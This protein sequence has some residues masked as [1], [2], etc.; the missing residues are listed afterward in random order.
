MQRIKLWA[1]LSSHPRNAK[2]WTIYE[3][4]LARLLVLAYGS[5]RRR[6]RAYATKQ[7]KVLS[8]KWKVSFAGWPSCNSLSRPLLPRYLQF[9][10]RTRLLSSPPQ[11]PSNAR[12]RARQEAR[13]QRSTAA[14]R[15]KRR[16]LLV[17]QVAVLTICIYRISCELEVCVRRSKEVACLPC[18]LALWCNSIVRDYLCHELYTPRLVFFSPASSIASMSACHSEKESHIH[19]LSSLVM[20]KEL[21][22]ARRNKRMVFFSD[23]QWFPQYE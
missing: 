23:T 16:R 14:G 11:P 9:S 8:T 3:A 15:L 22:K 12:K 13:R 2:R 19:S 17:L 21:G 6:I 20:S 10:F 5:R 7:A 18:V 4:W 1:L